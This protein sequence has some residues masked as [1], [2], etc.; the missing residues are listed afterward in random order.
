MS[1]IFEPLSLGVLTLPNRII[2]AP[3]TRGRAD[4]GSIPNAM[5]AEYYALRAEA[6]LIISEATAISP[7]AYGWLGAP[8]IWNDAQAVGWKLV[9]NAVHVKGG[10]M[11][12]QLWHMGRISHPDFQNGELPVAPSAIA[13]VGQS[14]TPSGKKDFVVP[15]E[16]TID[17][18]KALPHSY[19]EAAKRAMNAGFDGVEI[20][21]ANGYLLDEFIRDG[22]NQ[23]TDEYGGSIDNRIRLLI[24]VTNAVC[25]AIGADKVGV[26]LSP[27]SSHNSMHDSTPVATFTRAA[28]KL[29]TLG[30]AYLHVVEPFSG[31]RMYSEGE[32]VTPHIRKVFSGTLIANGGFTKPLANMM[33]ENA[34]ID[35]ASFGIMFLAN[36][37]LVLRLHHDHPLNVPNMETLYASGRLGYLDYPLYHDVAA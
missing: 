14:H 29:G 16:I 9:T 34:D 3:L 37:D 15:R 4:E 1:T 21:A 30:I 18:I 28:E 2:M 11:F 12:L 20:H 24:E 35:A 26:R 6:G 5:M 31:H 23:R 27:M 33:I 7:Q 13:A 32:R 36:P 10:R 19:A 25:H 22:S 8:G 17:E